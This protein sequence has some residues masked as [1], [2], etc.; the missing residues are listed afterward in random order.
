[1]GNQGADMHCTCLW[2][3]SGLP[4]EAFCSSNET[5]FYWPYKQ[6]CQLVVSQLTQPKYLGSVC[7]I[8]VNCDGT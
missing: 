2:V 1:M 5:E 7:C 3:E 8:L 4:L 6:Q